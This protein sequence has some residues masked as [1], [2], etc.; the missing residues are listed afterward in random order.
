MLICLLWSLA[1]IV[2]GTI[3]FL[4]RGF[5][6]LY[7][8]IRGARRGY[9]E[10]IG[11]PTLPYFQQNPLSNYAPFDS[12]PGRFD[13]DIFHRILIQKRPC[14]LPIDCEIALSAEVVNQ[15]FLYAFNQEYFFIQYKISF[16][17]MMNSLY[18]SGKLSANAVTFR[19]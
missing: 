17:K 15:T 13:N 18:S 1:R 14:V 19:V 10:A 12:T 4:N 9:L 16:Q 8:C 6:N 2:W 7:T 11:L 5:F 3:L